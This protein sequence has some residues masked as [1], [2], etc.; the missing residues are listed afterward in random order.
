ML[1]QWDDETLEPTRLVG[2][3]MSEPTARNQVN[4]ANSDAPSPLTKPHALALD[5]SETSARHQARKN[6]SPI[7]EIEPQTINPAPLNPTVLKQ[8]KPQAIAMIRQK[9]PYSNVIMIGDG[10]TDLE[11]VQVRRESCRG[12]N[13]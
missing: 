11:A 7:S 3:D 5:I 8:G 12:I 10:I 6:E 9:C 4:P 13:L 2:F 1:L